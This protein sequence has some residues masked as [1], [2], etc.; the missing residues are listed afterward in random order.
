M[1]SGLAIVWQ[2]ATLLA[3]EIVYFIRHGEPSY[4]KNPQKDT[5]PKEFVIVKFNA[6]EF[7]DSEELW[8]GLI[9]GIYDVVE[10]RMSEEKDSFGVTWKEIWRLK[11]SFEFLVET[12]GEQSFYPY[13][14]SAILISIVFV[15]QVFFFTIPEL[16]DE[17]FE[18]EDCLVLFLNAGSGFAYIKVLSGII[19][20]SSKKLLTSIGEAIVQE[21]KSISDRT[22]FLSSVKKELSELFEFIK[23]DF[24][25]GTGVDLSLV[26]IVDDLDRVFEGRSVKMLEAMQLVL[27]VPA[28]SSGFHL[29]GH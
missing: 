27:N 13:C 7:S 21:S 11:K 4:K 2:N 22:G 5:K 29:P 16:D 8:A 12:Y 3:L 23:G 24:C 28:R 9:K 18:W 1:S 14:L 6:W 19:S 25:I 10:E 20:V 15:I 17:A 26:L